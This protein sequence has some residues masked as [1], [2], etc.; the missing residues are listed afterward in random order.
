METGKFYPDMSWEDYRALDAINASTLKHMAK[1]A[2][3]CYE[4]EHS[5]QEETK[6]LRVGKAVHTAVLEP[7]R[8]ACDY[9]IADCLSRAAK[10][11]KDL[12]ASN[13]D[14]VI[15]TKTEADMISGMVNSLKENGHSEAMKLLE[16]DSYN[17]LSGVWTHKETGMLCKGRT[18]RYVNDQHGQPIIIDFKT[19]ADASTEV[20]SKSIYSYGYALSAAFYLD[21]WSAISG[22]DHGRFI[23]IAAEKEPPFE[24][25]VYELDFG[26]IEFGRAEYRS[27][28][29]RYAKAK[30]TNNWAGYPNSIQSIGLPAWAFNKISE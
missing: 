24:I 29:L 9:I 2:R 13:H 14:K 10:L 20:F 16:V 21:G 3:H 1:T 22:R 23:I 11:F 6:A 8:Y 7:E 18:D 28:L 27:H 15:I 30:H 17:E 5:P 26:C 19:T 25:A 4:Y 12:A